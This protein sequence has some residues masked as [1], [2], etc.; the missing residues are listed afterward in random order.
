[1]IIHT[2]ITEIV[3]CVIRNVTLKYVMIYS[4]IAHCSEVVI[5]SLK[6]CHWTMPLSSLFYHYWLTLYYIIFLWGW[7]LTIICIPTWGIMSA[8]TRGVMHKSWD[9]SRHLFIATSFPV[10]RM[11]KTHF[12][13]SKVVRTPEKQ[14]V[15]ILLRSLSKI[16][17]YI[18]SCVVSTRISFSISCC[19]NANT[20][21]LN[22]VSYGRSNRCCQHDRVK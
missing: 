5:V 8:I 6:M 12:K 21:L 10:N 16:Y 11:I 1:M 4:F 18:S 3:T 15:T 2:F 7:S 17:A 19:C 9:C 13:I 22:T 14:I 20:Y